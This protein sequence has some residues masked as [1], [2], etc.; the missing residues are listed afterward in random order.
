MRSIIKSLYH[1]SIVS[2]YPRMVLDTRIIRF[3]SEQRELLQVFWP[4]LSHLL[5]VRKVLK[6]F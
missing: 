4:F 5:M 1:R 3:S 2:G 6:A